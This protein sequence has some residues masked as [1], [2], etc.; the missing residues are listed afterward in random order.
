VVP[1]F[2]D[3]IELAVTL[4]QGIVQLRSHILVYYGPI[5][6]IDDLEQIK[7]WIKEVHK[8]LQGFGLSKAHA[9]M[10]S[11]DKRA[12]AR[13][14]HEVE[15]IGSGQTADVTKMQEVIEGLMR[16]LDSLTVINRREALLVHDKDMLSALNKR[17]DAALMDLQMYSLASARHNL[18]KGLGILQRLT[19]R[20]ELLD[21]FGVVTSHFDLTNS[22]PYELYALLCL[23]KRRIHTISNF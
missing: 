3:D 4:R 6:N 19:G 11:A 13:F 2:Q 9:V 14:A 16:F 10:R 21:Y 18:Q 22:T 7:G 20:D 12:I 8:L 17:M 15:L 5:R 23:I 1:H